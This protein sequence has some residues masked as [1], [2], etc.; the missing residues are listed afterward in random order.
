MKKVVRFLKV[1]SEWTDK[2]S[3]RNSVMTQVTWLPQGPGGAEVRWDRVRAL[4][5][6]IQQGRYRVA[7]V[8][9][10]D[11]LMQVMREGTSRRRR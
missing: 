5:E 2:G 7:S 1:F 6:A 9:L 3:G 10:A 8:D 11:K 4:R